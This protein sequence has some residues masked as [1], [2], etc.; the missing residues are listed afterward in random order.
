MD[1]TSPLAFETNIL[2]ELLP[3][4]I[5]FLIYKMAIVMPG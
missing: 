3:M 5:T 4:R 1:L 2:G